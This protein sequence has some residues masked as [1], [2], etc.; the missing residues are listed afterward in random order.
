MAMNQFIKNI[1]ALPRKIKEAWG[2]IKV[3]LQGLLI[4]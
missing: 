4:R 2:L 1:S 3:I